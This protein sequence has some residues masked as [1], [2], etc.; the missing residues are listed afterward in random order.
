MHGF[1]Q[2]NLL[3]PVLSLDC[4]II[5]CQEHWLMPELLYKLTDSVENFHCFST[6]AMA[7]KCGRGI[8]RGRPFG[9]MATFVRES[10]LNNVQC[11]TMTERVIAVKIGSYIVVNVYFP[12]YSNSDVY[13]NNVSDI[14]SSIES[15]I[16]SSPDC[17]MIIGGDFNLEFVNGISRCV[18]LNDFI[19]ACNLKLC[20]G[21]N[22]S[23]IQ[24]TYMCESRNAK[25]FIDHFIVS[26]VLFK[27]VLK[28]VT[29]DIGINLSDHVPLAMHLSVDPTVLSKSTMSYVNNVKRPSRL[30]WDKA[31]LMHYYHASHAHL[32]CI[33]V[34]DLSQ[35]N[36]GCHC[37]K[38][39][40]VD[41]IYNKIVGALC[42]AAE[43]ACPRISASHYKS[44]WDD[45]LA[46]LKS[47]SIDT[48][49][50]WITC[51]RPTRGIIYI[52]RCRA[53]AEYRRAI[54][55]KRDAA[56]IS[57]SNDLNDYLLSKDNISFWKTWKSKFSAKHSV[58]NS[59]DGLSQPVDIAN[60]FAENFCDAT[61]PNNKSRSEEL[62]QPHQAARLPGA[63]G[64]GG[65]R[66][67]RI[68]AGALLRRLH[69]HTT[70]AGQPDRAGGAGQA[71]GW[72]AQH[73]HGV[74][75][76]RAQ[77]HAHQFADGLQRLPAG[78]GAGRAL[79]APG[80]VTLPHLL[81]DA[82]WWWG[83]ITRL[84]E[85]QILLPAMALALV[86]LWRQPGG[87]PLAL[88][89][90][91]ATGVAASITTVS[92][93]AFLGFGIGHA[94]LDFTGFS[95][96]A[97]FAAALMPVLVRLA[98]G[99]RSAMA[100]AACCCWATCWRWLWRCHG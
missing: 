81:V 72:L 77:D 88:A 55:Y 51:G 93:V 14:L 50:L 7:D 18:L 74:G 78:S 85:A 39:K 87:R 25:S 9:G 68:P 19:N 67:H 82:T 58:A 13:F 31:D 100:G 90:L 83:Q 49:L 33:D 12:V 35:C 17:H 76:R 65:R 24:Y 99:P 37:N 94:P 46:D 36:P 89:W 70:A 11:L 16:H 41:S 30:R 57:V 61:K 91:L 86:W 56:D 15:L 42:R 53:R 47:K 21:A 54:K 63:A 60:T 29:V 2:G 40:V 10:L 95:G 22:D 73:G 38:I 62:R 27:N 6:S 98:A 48:H 84:G 79:Q 32:S 34:K 92:K 26:D 97:M 20:D 59:V 71:G 45:E 28:Y 3:L 66:P 75:Q 64:R 4:D 23:A 52:N 5:L 1:N 8:L 43:E 44:F 80:P 69:P 96:H